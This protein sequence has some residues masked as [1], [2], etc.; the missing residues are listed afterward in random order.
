MK[1]LSGIF[2][3][4]LLTLVACGPEDEIVNPDNSG[5]QTGTDLNTGTVSESAQDVLR[6]ST[7][8]QQLE[9]F[10][11]GRPSILNSG[12]GLAGGRSI[13]ANGRILEDD[14]LSTDEWDEMDQELLELFEALEE[15]E[16]QIDALDDQLSNTNDEAERDQIESDIE[17][18]ELELEE[19]EEQIEELWD[20]HDYE[21]DY[22]L[23]DCEYTSC[24]AEEFTENGDGSYTWVIDYGDDGC[25]EYDGYRL[26][27]KMTETYRE[28]E[29]GFSGTIVY[30]NFGDDEYMMSGTENFSGTHEDFED[31]LN[32]SGS[33][34]YSEDLVV[35]I[36]GEVFTV[37]SSGTETFDANGFTSTFTERYEASNG[38]YADVKTT[39]PL[40]FSFACEEQDVFE[41]VSGVEV[42]SYQEGSESGELITD[43]GDGTCDNILSITEDGETFQVDAELEDW[44]DDEDDEG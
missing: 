41:Y 8:I 22:Y 39:T 2:G 18:L 15:L 13:P 6:I 5:N 12:F 34:T 25:E 31:S 21:D 35:T 36:D 42:I 14:S 23:E 28:D 4:V 7:K 9:R 40:Y 20:D 38:D 43:F 26:R 27:G 44:D 24:A 1:Y 29:N 37:Q 10:G 17:Q 33:Y 3:F 30:E 32:F 16:E 11:F 19:I